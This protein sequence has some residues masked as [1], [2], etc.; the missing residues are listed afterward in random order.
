M[1]KKRERPVPLSRWHERVMKHAAGGIDAELPDLPSPEIQ[2]QFVGSSLEPA[3]EEAFAFYSTFEGY[4]AALAMPMQAEGARFLDFGCGWGR[5]LRYAMND[6]PSERLFA[7][8]ID[9]GIID[10]CEV[11][12]IPATFTLVEPM[13]ELPFPDGFFSHVM[14]YSVFTHLPEK[15]HLNWSAEIIR[16]LK[17]GGVFCGTIETR[18][19]LEFIQNI[20]DTDDFPND[21]QRALARYRLQTPSLL[22]AYDAGQFVY[23]P[24]GGGGVRTADVYGEAVISPAYIERNWHGVSLRAVLD[25]RFWQTVIIVQKH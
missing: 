17:P 18:K 25:E 15:V 6:F 7:T 10:V 16:V 8:D 12:G 20:P 22:K 14:A 13:G 11:A 23:L 19:F 3:F 5:F 2:E 21:W 1:K 9:A 24:T 4:A